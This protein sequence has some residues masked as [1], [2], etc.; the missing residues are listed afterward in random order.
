MGQK[1]VN[2]W[3][4]LDQTFIKFDEKSSE[5]DQKLKDTTKQLFKEKLQTGELNE[6]EIEINIA[7]PQI[8]MEIM[9]PPG[10]VDMTQ[11]LQN[12]FSSLGSDKKKRRKIKYTIYCVYRL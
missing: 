11:Q 8:N 12:M 4:K 9:G 2:I 5:I 10:M 1:G 3:W 6:Q 7:E